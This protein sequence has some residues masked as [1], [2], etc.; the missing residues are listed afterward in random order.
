MLRFVYGTIAKIREREGPATVLTFKG[1]K[2]VIGAE[3]LE[4]LGLKVDP[5]TGKL[6]EIR[7]KGLAY[8][9]CGDKKR[10]KIWDIR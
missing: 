7:P 8:F 3:T 5:T 9:Y 10:R 1:V 6:E 4:S 2:S